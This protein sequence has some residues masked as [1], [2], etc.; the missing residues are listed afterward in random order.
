MYPF[1][2]RAAV[3]Q[4]AYSAFSTE[5]LI[6]FDYSDLNAAVPFTEDV[7]TSIRIGTGLCIF[8]PIIDTGTCGLVVSASSLPDWNATDASTYPVG[9]EF[10][11]SNKR[12]YSGHWIPSG[13]YFINAEVEVKAQI[14]ILAVEAVTNCT[15]CNETTDTSICPTPTSG[16]PPVVTTMPTRILNMGVGFGRESDG[17]PHGTPDKSPFLNIQSIN[18]ISLINNPHFRNGYVISED[19]ITIG[20]TASNTADFK[21]SKLALPPNATD[22][23]D[24]A[25]VECCMAVDG[26]NS[27]FGSALIDT[28]VSQMYMTVPLGTAVNRSV[29]PLL[30]NGSM[31]NVYLGSYPN[32]VAAESFTVGDEAGMNDSVVPSSVRLTLADPLVN[33]PH[34]NTG[35]RFLR[36]WKVAFDIDGGFLG[37]AA[38]GNQCRWTVNSV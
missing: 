21:F 33:V 37:F 1:L 34:V 7:R 36:A 10:L 32:F 27:T 5:V 16:P 26:A 15:N 35:R 23:R 6:P 25:P 2:S 4:A 20:L 13:I 18:A 8:H 11:S 12:L 24:W 17:Q 9:W 19:G 31:V 3:V 30:D 22:P 29:P 28:G 38:V 14:P